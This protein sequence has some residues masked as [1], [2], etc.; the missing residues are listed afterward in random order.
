MK[1]AILQRKA[2]ERYIQPSGSID[3]HSICTQ[4]ITSRGILM[5]LRPRSIQWSSIECAKALQRSSDVNEDD[6]KALQRSSGL[7]ED[8]LRLQPQ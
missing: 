8:D 6:P 7:N 1:S 3:P 2:G 5:E 4:A